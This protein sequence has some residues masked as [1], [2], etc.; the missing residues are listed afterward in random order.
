MNVKAIVAAVCIAGLSIVGFPSIA[1]AQVPTPA[2]VSADPVDNTPH[3]LDGEVE[4]IARIGH[5]V[6]VG[7]DFTQVRAYGTSLILSRNNLFAYDE[8]TGAISTNFMPTIGPVGKDITSIIPAGDGTSVFISGSFTTVNGANTGRVARLD[9]NTGKTVSTFKAARPNAAVNDMALSN[10]RLIIAG[11][12]ANL[13][14]PGGTAVSRPGIA[15]LDPATGALTS[16]VTDAFSG[17]GTKGSTSV[18]RIDVTPAGD[19]LIAIGNF[20]AVDG[21]ARLQVAQLDISGPTSSLSTWQTSQ[22]P[23]FESNHTT[24]WCSSS[25][26]TYMRDVSYSADGSYFMIVTTGAYRSGRL[27]DTQTRWETSGGAN[28]VP[29]WIQYTG[30]DTTTDVAAAANGRVIYVGGH[31]RWLNN[32]FQADQAGQGAV[33]RIGLAAIDPRNGMPYSWN[34]TRDRGYGVYSFLPTNDGLFVGSDTN[35]LANEFHPRLGFFPAAGGLSLP[36]EHM[37]A[38]PADVYML[39]RTSGT[40]T[41]DLRKLS[42]TGTTSGALSTSAGTESWGSVR[43]AFS[44]D[45]LVYT[46]WSDGTLRVRTFNGTTFGP[47]ST[48]PMSSPDPN[49]VSGFTP[50]NNFVS[51]IPSITGMFYDK[52]LGRLYY[53]MSNSSSLYYRYFEPESRIVGAQRFTATGSTTALDPTNVRGMFLAGGN[54]YFPS[55]SGQLKRIGFA[56]GQLAAGSATTVNTSTDWR[57]RGMFAWDGGVDPNTAPVA[58]ASATCTI[59]TCSFDST[60]TDDIDGTIASY[61]WD[62]GDGTPTQTGATASHIYTAD[63]HFNVQLTVTDNR[64]A[65]TTTSVG[66]DPFLPPNIVPTANATAHCVARTCSF[67]GSGSTDTDG[68]IA[69]YS[70]DFSDG[71]PS[72]TGAVVSHTFGADGHYTGTLTVTD[73]SGDTS[74]NSVDVDV[75]L[76]PNELPTAVATVNCVSLTC[77]FDGSTSSDTD[78]TIVSYSWD[79]SDGPP[80]VSGSN[81][82][83]TFATDGHYTGTL[84]VTDD[85]GGTSTTSVDADVARP[86]NVLPTANLTSHC[87]A[88][89]CSFDGTTSTDSDGNLVGYEWDFG[90]NTPTQT[91]SVVTHHYDT[92]GDY[93]VHLTVTDDRGGQNTATGSASPRQVASNV[94]FRAS[95]TY[96]GGTVVKHTV[97]VPATVQPGDGMVMFVTSNTSSAIATPPAGWTQLSTVLN[98]E[99]RSTLFYKVAAPGEAGTNV[100]VTL[101]A[102]SKTDIQLSAYSGVSSDLPTFASIANPSTLTDRPAPDLTVPADG[103]WVLSYWSDKSAATT[104]W[105]TPVGEVVRGQSTGAGGG[106]IT[107]LLTDDGGPVFAGPRTGLT[108]ATDV[109]SSRAISWTVALPTS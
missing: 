48:V 76:P 17:I 109:A 15:S 11:D 56:N 47:F 89:N 87:V 55:T 67:D 75:V 35:S 86:P 70:W 5:T 64:G 23:A 103:A 78:G 94:N 33:S 62:F 24:T 108:S 19:R 50:T 95:L 71:P 60:G 88:Q 97:K 52:S 102:A 37:S 73:N 4:A 100:T 49:S 101:A 90:D 29:T 105:S 53:T 91:G 45:N 31:F 99:M 14:P 25:F 27:C 74:T 79:F 46:G 83:H 84:T 21:Q 81:V 58:H 34:P 68:T 85:L 59:R 77:S 41:N 92:P 42:F 26:P 36:S 54:I 80:S 12:F 20:S 3:V 6:I 43:G 107:S 61:T 2:Q 39:G 82:P 7:G 98:A 106:H 13:T 72:Q 22:Y 9:I 40:S 38:L 10:G 8:V 32:P 57:T 1:S 104:T 16:N 63:G 96:S 18:R 44:V 28:Q 93:V 30:G 66:V 51:D 69:S 65:S